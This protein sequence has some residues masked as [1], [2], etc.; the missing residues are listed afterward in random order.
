MLAQRFAGRTLH[1]TT[2]ETQGA[3]LTAYAAGGGGEKCLIA[4]FNKD[5]HDAKV[6]FATAAYDFKRASVERLEAPAIDSKLG[7]PCREATGR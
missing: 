5:A 1:R 6:A 7:R 2:L 3:N 4:I